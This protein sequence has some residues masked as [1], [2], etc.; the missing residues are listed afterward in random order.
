MM[1]QKQLI[2]VNIP[3]VL[4]CPVSDTFT[5]LLIPI[6]TLYVAVYVFCYGYS[7]GCSDGLN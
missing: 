3:L 6:R 2:V 5:V 1:L 7:S 4:M